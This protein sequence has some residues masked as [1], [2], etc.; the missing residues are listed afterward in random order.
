MTDSVVYGVRDIAAYPTTREQGR[1]GRETIDRLL[2]GRRDVE[3]T[4]SFDEVA[5]MTH[6]FIDE[7]LGR[8]LSMD[9]LQRRSI[10]L[11]VTSLSS[12]N[13]ETLEVCLE[14]R[15]QLVAH[16]EPGADLT[17]V[18]ADRVSLETFSAVLHKHSATAADVAKRLGI[19]PQN[20]NNRLT[21]LTRFGAVRKS[22]V[23]SGGR[24]GKEFSYEGVTDEVPTLVSCQTQL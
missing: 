10:T 3:L 4:V 18:A 5:G 15:H 11:K 2:E 6:S 17:L 19:S 7:F 12:E 16:V 22:Q 24:G 21:R 20:A 14:R 23:T 8:L 1:A 13:L 9:E